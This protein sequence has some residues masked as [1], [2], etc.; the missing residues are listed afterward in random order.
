MVDSH[1]NEYVRFKIALTEIELTITPW[2][3]AICAELSDS[4]LPVEL[5][6]Q[7]LEALHA[8]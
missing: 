1:L 7:W 3:A 5:A 6:L 4:S 2:N 8:R